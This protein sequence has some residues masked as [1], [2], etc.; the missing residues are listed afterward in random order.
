MCNDYRVKIPPA[1]YVE[2]FSQI[3]I[4]F[5]WATGG[6]PNLEPREDVRIKDTAPVVRWA[7]DAAELTMLPWSWD[8]K[9]RPVFNF[10]S[11]GRDFAKSERVLIPTDGFYE[12]TTPADPK[13]K[14]KDKWLF[15]LTGEPWFWI[16]GIVKEGAFTMLTTEPGPDVKPYH[17]RQVVVVPLARTADWLVNAAADVL[18]PLPAGSLEVTAVPRP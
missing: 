18:T 4:P 3:K 16:A 6:P 2:G 5:K 7:G 8:Q 14:L 9:G 17:D 11:E 1:G 13:Q 12:F 15:T 10:R